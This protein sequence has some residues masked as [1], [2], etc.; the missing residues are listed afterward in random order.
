VSRSAART[1]R[2]VVS[3][4]SAARATRFVV[5]ARVPARSAG[6]AAA[7]RA[8]GLSTLCRMFAPALIA[9]RLIFVKISH[10]FPPLNPFD[11]IHYNKSALKRQPSEACAGYDFSTE[12]SKIVKY[13]VIFT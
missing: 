3:T 4:R 11:M 8:P 1:T 2:F 6:F 13:W 10:N 5:S 12:A 9:A 7:V